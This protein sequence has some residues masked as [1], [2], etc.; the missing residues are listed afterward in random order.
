MRDDLLSA[1]AGAGF[2]MTRQRRIIAA[3]L[4]QDPCR[5]LTA[6]VLHQELLAIGQSLS[7]ATIYN[8]LREFARLGLIRQVPSGGGPAQFDVRPG[9]H[10]HFHIK[11]EGR[12]IDIPEDAIRFDC[13]PLPPEGYRIM[14]VDVTL[15]LEPVRPQDMK[16]PHAEVIDCPL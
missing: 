15:H 1:I 4:D 13:L 9:N 16:E 5:H 2:R 11:A 10:H 7:L 12:V 6:E 3:Y 14:A 8:T